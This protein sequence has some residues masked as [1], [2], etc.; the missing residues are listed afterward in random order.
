MRP[1]WVLTTEQRANTVLKT[2]VAREVVLALHERAQVVSYRANDGKAVFR[3]SNN[4]GLYLD[5]V[6]DTHAAQ[7]VDGVFAA[8]PRFFAELFRVRPVAATDD[9]ALKYDLLASNFR[10]LNRCDMLAADVSNLRKAFLDLDR[11]KK[12]KRTDES[13]SPDSPLSFEIDSNQALDSSDQEQSLG[14]RA[15]SDSSVVPAHVSPLVPYE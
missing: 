11:A 2:Q 15:R 14:K 4:D 12:R 9:L 13:S 6:T 7:P 10:L 8:L 5:F 3:H 1:H